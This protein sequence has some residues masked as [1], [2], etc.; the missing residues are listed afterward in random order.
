M[1]VTLQTVL[2]EVQ[3]IDTTNL[4][5]AVAA[6]A[7]VTTD[8]QTLIAAGPVLPATTPVTPATS[9][10]ITISGTLSGTTITNLNG[11]VG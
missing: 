6:L 8:L 3:A 7:Q 10:T 2:A 4:D 9:G 1:T 11:R 5:V